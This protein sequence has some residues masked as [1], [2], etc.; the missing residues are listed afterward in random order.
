R[1][2]GELLFLTKPP[3]DYFDRY[4]NERR[5]ARFRDRTGVF[6]TPRG[7]DV[8]NSVL[9]GKK[10]RPQNSGDLGS[11]PVAGDLALVLRVAMLGYLV[12]G[13]LGTRVSCGSQ[14]VRGKVP[15]PYMAVAANRNQPPMGFD[16]STAAYHQALCFY[17]TNQIISQVGPDDILVDTNC[18]LII[19]LLKLSRLS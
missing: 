10:G 18:Q 16:I 6:W 11:I 15:S 7:V 4:P 8:V 17:L 9:R 14:P 12:W 1:S 13:S 2:S 3:Q 5:P 19:A